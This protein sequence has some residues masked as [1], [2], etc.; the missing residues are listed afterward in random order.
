[1]AKNKTV[2]ITGATGTIGQAITQSMDIEK[3]DIIFTARSEEKARKLMSNLKNF[4][5]TNSVTYKI[6]DLGNKDQIR[7][8]ANDVD[9][10]IDILINNAAITPRARMLNESGIEM[11]WAVNVLGY[12]WMM[13]YFTP[14]LKQGFHPRIVNVASYWAGHLDLTDPEFEKR[15]YDNNIA[16]M[17]SKQADRMLSKA[18]SAILKKERIAVNSCHPGDANSNLSNSLG[19]GGHESPQRAAETPVFLA[20]NET[21][22]AKTGCYFRNQSEISCAF[23]QNKTQV[24]EL[25][26]LCENY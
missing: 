21:G 12:F 26:R 19:F 10:P 16:Y 13:K 3:F 6:I 22:F 17:Q 5:G 23:S 20:T 4:S 7:Q 9:Q 2:I 18:F 8:F 11:Q 25:Y 15:N 24:D 1:M 14:H